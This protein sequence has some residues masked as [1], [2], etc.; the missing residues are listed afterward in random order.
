MRA[1]GIDPGI[2]PEFFHRLGLAA[3]TWSLSKTEVASFAVAVAAGDEASMAKMLR[4]KRRFAE[5]GLAELTA[6]VAGAL[7]PGG[8]PALGVR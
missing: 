6:A 2:P 3:C 1:A 5:V 4:Q 8:I 7:R